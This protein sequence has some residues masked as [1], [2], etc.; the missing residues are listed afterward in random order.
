MLALKFEFENNK[1]KKHIYIFSSTTR[2]TIWCIYN[3]KISD[4]KL[5]LNNGRASDW[6]SKEIKEQGF[7]L[8]P[9]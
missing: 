7:N 1:N 4:F 2:P 9:I 3:S 6:C 5:I 8:L